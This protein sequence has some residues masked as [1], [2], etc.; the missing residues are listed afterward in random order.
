MLAGPVHAEQN[1][2]ISARRKDMIGATLYL[3]IYN[4]GNWRI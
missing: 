1:A 2:I 4:P 3:T